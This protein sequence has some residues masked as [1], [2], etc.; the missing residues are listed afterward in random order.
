MSDTTHQERILDQFTR[1]ATPFSTASPITDANALRMIVEAADPQP[2]DTVLDVAC[3]GGLVVCAF[4]PHVKH[5]TGIDMTPA[6]LDRA[7]QLAAEK[8]IA[9]VTWDRGDVGRLP[10]DD[11]GFDIVVTRFSMHHFLDPLSVMRE[12]ARVCAPGGRVVVVDMYAADD[13]AKA[14]E[15]NR[16]EKL[17]DPSHV[18][19]LTLP[20]LKGLFGGAGMREPR[21]GFYELR[22][23]IRNL[24]ARSFP[25]PGDDVKIIEMYAASAE[26]GRLGIPV[27]RDG[28]RID[29][30]FP[31]AILASTVIARG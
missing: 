14:A 6:M 17:R 7:Q 30:A 29:Y 20:E 11:G 23:E 22:D 13:P 24:L 18:R 28:E 3:G 19:C 15:W 31:I 12:M 2:G 4:A 1:Q 27:R 25:N 21:A 16:A 5:A 9:N 10:Y 8:G 26:D